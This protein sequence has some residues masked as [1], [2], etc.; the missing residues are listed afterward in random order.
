MH[1]KK[2]SRGRLA[3][4]TVRSQKICNIRLYLVPSL[5]TKREISLSY[6]TWIKS[7]KRSVGINLDLDC[8]GQPNKET[9]VS[10]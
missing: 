6:A 7:S 2:R 1:T 9:M 3:K 8:I 10:L 5:Y 4:I